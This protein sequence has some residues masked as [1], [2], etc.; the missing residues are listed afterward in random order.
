VPSE[1]SPYVCDHRILV[2]VRLKCTKCFLL[3][4]CCKRKQASGSARESSVESKCGDA[5]T[6]GVREELKVVKRSAP[7][8][9][10]RENVAPARL[11]FVTVRKLDVCV[12]EWRGARG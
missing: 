3:P 11:T 6:R 12:W 1:A 10:A 4:L 9:E 8:A 5:A 7:R 2:L